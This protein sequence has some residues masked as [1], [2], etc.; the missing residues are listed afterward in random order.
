MI[1]DLLTALA[2]GEREARRRLLHTA[3]LE[4]RG[5]DLYGR[6]EILHHL[7]AA[8]IGPGESVVAGRLAAVT[9]EAGEALVAEFAGDQV[10]RL[11][12]LGAGAGTT[13]ASPR[14]DV[15][16][17]HAL[18]QVASAAWR[19]EDHPELADGDAAAIEALIA[20]PRDPD[21]V[22]ARALVLRA[23][24]SPEGPLALVRL[25]GRAPGSGRPI[26]AYALG[27][28]RGGE[29]TRLVDRAGLAAE[30]RRE[31]SPRL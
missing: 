29:F 2:R 23:G 10:A 22:E 18:G 8:P 16:R 30:L 25:E 11:W 27:L 31:W 6:D 20:W 3:R 21:V 9:T 13:A 12:V 14:I 26:G 7:A 4:G 17:D 28:A 15:P 24:S 19:R 5:A 1:A